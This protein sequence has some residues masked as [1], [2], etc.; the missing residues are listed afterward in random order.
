MK[1]LLLFSLLFAMLLNVQ[2]QKIEFENEYE[3]ASLKTDSYLGEVEYNPADK[4]TSL[5][6][7]EKDMLKT[8]FTTYHFDE[9]MQF[10]NEESKDFS[11]IDATKEEIAAVRNSFAWFDYRG[12]SYT[13]E[14][15]DV[16][17]SFGGKLIA[18]RQKVTYNFNWNL[19]IYLPK[20]DK[21]ENVKIKG[22]ADQKIYLYDHVVNTETGVAYLL[23]GVK[24]PKGSDEKYLHTRNFQIVKLNQNLEVEYLEEIKFDYNMAIS[25]KRLV[26]EEGFAP[27]EEMEVEDINKGKLYM[28]FSPIKTMLGKK[29]RSPNA[30]DNTLV[31]VDENGKIEA[32]VEFT[33]KTTGWVIEDMVLDKTNDLYFYGPAKDEA[34]VN[35]VMPTN[36]PLTS[37]TE[38]KDIKW[39]NF[40]VMKISDYRFQWINST[41]LK[42]FKA[43]AVAPPSQKKMPVYVGKKFAIGISFITPGGELIITGQ[44][45]TTKS[46]PDPKKEGST[47]KVIDEYKDLVMFHFDDKGILKA[48]YGIRRDKMNRYSKA[49][50]T[51]Q[52]IYMSPDGNSMYWVYGEI[53]G[54]RS[55]LALTGG[56]LEVAGVSTLAKRKLLYYPA[57]AIVNLAEGKIGDFV[58]LGRDAEG[59]QR[60]YTHPNI[61]QIF[62]P[63]GKYLTFIGENKKGSSVWLARM[64]VN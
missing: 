57:V 8:T 47:M 14:F 2:S 19:G 24:A 29:F 55:G 49:Y 23:V 27:D 10:I 16:Y 30:G 48:Q 9:K 7:V 50:I 39:K 13:K 38:V 15:I 11:I 3:F 52:D 22:D 40:Q 26:Y 54:M 20:F 28:V 60:F 1:K 4:T 21:A 18:T 45:Y 64:M 56:L 46:A 62:S 36:S 41:D 59:K 63:D 42:E 31:V 5:Y 58:P 34:Y 43:K 12:E 6:Y 25:F 33:T 44:K 35:S 61:P 17:P 32:K 53:K 51:P 37:R